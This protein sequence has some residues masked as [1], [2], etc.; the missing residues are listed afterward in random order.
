MSDTQ[1]LV[2]GGGLAGCL[3]ACLLHDRGVDVMIVDQHGEAM[4]GA[5]RWNEGKVHFGY[6]YVGTDSVRTAELM[7][8]GAT[9]FHPILERVIG[10]RLAA[11]VFTD[12]ITYLV[13]TGSI[14]PAETLWQRTLAVHRLVEEAISQSPAL[15]AGLPDQRLVR[16]DPEEA[17]AATRQSNVAAAWSTPERALSARVLADIVAAAVHDRGIPVVRAVV[18]AVTQQDGEWQM[19]TSGGLLCSRVAVNALWEGRSR[20]DRPF[21]EPHPVSI[22]WKAGIFARRQTQFAGVTPST[23]IL[24]GFGDVTPYNNGDVYLGWYPSN[25]IARSDTGAPPA[26]PA[27]D[28]SEMLRQTLEGLRFPA[29][30]LDDVDPETC[31]QGG[32]VVAQGSGDIYEIASPLHERSAAFAVELAPGLVSVDT[33]KLTTAPLFADR[34]ARLVLARLGMEVAA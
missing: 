4:Q 13:D 18:D 7:L 15:V 28:R 31:V 3:T 27:F 34:A 32:Y 1:V 33:G 17:A 24:G 20:I 19:S 5:S 21:R 22:R 25:M 14:F 16:L 11:D 9:A 10:G 8:A 30:I 2:A 29:S 26:I 6:T 12:R 23:R